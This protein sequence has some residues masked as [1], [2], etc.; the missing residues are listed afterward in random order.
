[1]ALPPPMKALRT[2][3]EI[4]LNGEAHQRKTS[5]LDARGVCILHDVPVR[6]GTSCEVAFPYFLGKVRQLARIEGTVRSS[7]FADRGC[8]LYVTF[9]GIPASSPLPF[10]SAY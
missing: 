4:I 8:R 1:M 5:H 7:V 2:P 3:V 10:L 6:I 9:S